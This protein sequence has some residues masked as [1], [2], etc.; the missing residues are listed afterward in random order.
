MA[1]SFSY[2]PISGQKQA[3]GFSYTPENSTQASGFSY[4]PVE[5]TW[6]QVATDT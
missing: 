1:N 3:S 6:G 5:R 4:T 2:T